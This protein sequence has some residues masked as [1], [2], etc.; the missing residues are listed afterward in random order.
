MRFSFLYNLYKGTNKKGVKC[1]YIYDDLLDYARKYPGKIYSDQDFQS[2]GKFD[3]LFVFFGDDMPK[4][5][6]EEKAML[7][8][9]TVISCLD[10]DA[11]I[12]ELSNLLEDPF[13]TYYFTFCHYLNIYVRE[14]LIDK[15]KL[16]LLG[17]NLSTKSNN[18]DII[19]LGLT[20]LGISGNEQGREI[21][22]V[23]GLHS[24][25]TFYAITAFEYMDLH[26]KYV[27]EMA[28]KTYGFGKVHCIQNIEPLTDDIKV[29]L[30]ENGCDNVV[31]PKISAIISAQKASMSWYLKSRKVDKRAFSNISRL[32]YYIFSPDKNDVYEFHDSLETITEYMKYA[33]HYAK[34]FEDL[35]AVAYIKKWMRPFWNPGEDDVKKKNGWS[36]NIESD[37]RNK[38]IDILKN[39]KWKDVLNN[40]LR[41]A[42]ADTDTY[43][44]LASELDVDLSFSDLVPLLEK[45]PLDYKISY[46]ISK[47]GNEASM[48]SFIEYAKKTIDFDEMELKP[49]DEGLKDDDLSFENK[50]DIFL[51]YILKNLSD[52]KLVELDLPQIALTT[53]YD[54]NRIEAITY[55]RNYEDAWD[56]NVEKSLLNALDKEPNKGI[57]K[58]LMRLLGKRENDGFED[59]KK[60]VRY[61]DIKKQIVKPNVKDVYLFS[62]YVAGLFYRDMDVVHNHLDKGD[63]LY[64]KREPENPYDKNAIMVTTEDGYVLGYIPKKENSLFQRLLDAGKYLYAIVDEFLED[65]NKLDIDL[66]LS[67]RDVVENTKEIISMLIENPS[68]YNS[69]M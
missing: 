27:F 13:I 48:K 23:L 15:E 50:S 9:K 36:S 3:T 7:L 56:E 33:K 62:T 4:E 28:N 18:S 34:S 41:S 24:E 35:C 61:V 60:E 59:I 68:I 16:Y 44:Y 21:A 32:I 64:L 57:K 51:Y 66:Y 6:E 55:L 65:S 12:G 47:S 67:Y 8:L 46:Y 69:K 58:R 11:S 49:S 29:W 14:R 10:G 20:L 17:R 25:F 19:K 45:D 2:A 63:I 42:E 40:S 26:N 54:G 30:I 22:S 37:I 39:N 53:R 5:Y 52:Y 31:M 38:C 1:V 43:I